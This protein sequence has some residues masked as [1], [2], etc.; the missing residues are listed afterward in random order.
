MYLEAVGGV[1]TCTELRTSA[2]GASGANS[3][4]ALDS[5]G[6]VHAY[7]LALRNVFIIAVPAG[8]EGIYLC[9]YV[10]Q[11]D[12]VRRRRPRVFCP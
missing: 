12:P 4:R 8:E 10:P 6:V 2:Y 7:V 11:P 9:A 1:L 5:F 3:R